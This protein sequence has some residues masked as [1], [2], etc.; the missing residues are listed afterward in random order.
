MFIFFRNVSTHFCFSRTAIYQFDEAN[1]LT[2]SLNHLFNDEIHARSHIVSRSLM[3]WEYRQQNSHLTPSAADKK[4]VNKRHARLVYLRG[5]ARAE[6]IISKFKLRKP[7]RE[8]VNEYCTEKEW[9]DANTLMQIINHCWRPQ[10]SSSVRGNQR[11]R[12]TRGA[13]VHLR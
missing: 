11:N 10:P 6:E 8:Q 12:A 1:E 4:V 3:L 13:Q 7:T 9:R 5:K 2:L